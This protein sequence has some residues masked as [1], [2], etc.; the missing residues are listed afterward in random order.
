MDKVWIVEEVRKDNTSVI[1]DVHK[2]LES[3]KASILGWEQCD[4]DS[5][6]FHTVTVMRLQG[7]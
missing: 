5:V 4:D 1:L 7:K 6:Q 2:S 3:A